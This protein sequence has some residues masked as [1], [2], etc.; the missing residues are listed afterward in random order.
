[1]NNR[2]QPGCDG[3]QEN[4]TAPASHPS[5]PTGEKVPGGSW[6]EARHR[7]LFILLTA[8][9]LVG[10]I[11]YAQ[12]GGG[13]FG[14]RGGGMRR[15]D[16]FGESNSSSPTWK[17]P[18]A[19]K[20]DVFSF[21]HIQYDAGGFGGR[22]GWATDYRDADI[23]VLLRLQQITSMKVNDDPEGRVLRLTDPNLTKHPFIY[24]VESGSLYLSDAE[25]G[26]L[27]KHL[28]NGGFLML[29][30]FWGQA[31]W[32]NMEHEIKKAFPDRD[33]ADVPP[34]HPIFNG[35]FKLERDKLQTPGIG[36]FRGYGSDITYE[37]NHAGG[38]V[39]DVHFRAIYDDKGRMIVLACHNTD[40]GDGWEREG[41]NEEYFKEFSSK[42][43]YPLAVN[44]ILYMMSH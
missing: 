31:E 10:S 3:Q 32:D 41:L 12:R 8:L 2:D 28:L 37:P 7:R 16:G 26:L 5:P 33:F 17:N 42:K 13:R 40:N 19:F 30:D 1:M 29:D 39:K 35:L 44:V 18:D 25:A 11:A 36:N 22:G 43:C 20:H 34:D 27:R 23:N 15:G 6:L 9:L 21:V 24:I 4:D 38:N 14:G